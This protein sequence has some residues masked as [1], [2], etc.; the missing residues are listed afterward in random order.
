M[1]KLTLTD[2]DSSK[3]SSIISKSNANNTAVEVALEKT[4]SRDGTGPNSMEATLDMN[5]NRIINLP[6]P[7]SETEPLLKGKFDE[8]VSL[9]AADGAFPAHLVVPDPHPEYATDADLAAHEAA[10]DPH[11]QYSLYGDDWVNPYDPNNY[12]SSIVPVSLGTV[13]LLCDP[14][15]GDDFEDMAYWCAGNNRGN[16]FVDLA[17]V[18]GLHAVNANLTINQQRYLN[19]Y[20]NTAPTFCDIAG[21]TFTVILGSLVEATVS[22]NPLT[23]LPSYVTVGWTLGGQNIRGD[24]SA[25]LLNNAHQ[26]TEIAPDR[27]SYKAQIRSFGVALADFTTLDNTNSFGSPVP[28]NKICV[29]RAVLRMDHNGWDGTAIEGFLNTRRGGRIDLTNIGFSYDGPSNNAKDILFAGG[30]GS[31]I[32]CV[33]YVLCAGSGEMTLRSFDKGHITANRSFFGGDATGLHVWQGSANG[34]L[35]LTR[36]WAGS[37]TS[38]LI[39]GAFAGKADILSSV[40]AGGNQLVRPVQRNVEINLASVHIAHGAI[41]LTGTD[42]VISVDTNCVIHSCTDPFFM[43]GVTIKGNPSVVACTNPVPTANVVDDNGGLWST[44]QFRSKHDG[45]QLIG[46]TTVVLNFGSIPD[47]ASGTPFLELTATLAGVSPYDL[48]FVRPSAK[49]PSSTVDYEVQYSATDEVTVRAKNYG[50]TAVDPAAATL[51]I[52]AYRVTL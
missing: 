36:C 27:L 25:R 18:D 16:K 28:P 33:D 6:E 45:L 51:K 12:I 46:E 49:W 17:L 15:S 40:L 10:P 26:V 21:A 44:G 34:S 35:R 30:L 41:G 37:V 29:P 23:P 32:E 1:A 7:V 2:L 39:S 11:P 22:L 43:A 4:L 24:G 5:S 19:F 3:A 42:G 9:L 8:I 48:I 31:I 20:G 50:N 52:T 38:D 14:T 13:K 47:A